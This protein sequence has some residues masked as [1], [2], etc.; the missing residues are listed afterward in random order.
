MQAEQTL[1]SN[2]VYEECDMPLAHT[3]LGNIVKVSDLTRSIQM[4]TANMNQ[5]EYS[6]NE[7][8]IP[9]ESSIA[10]NV[11]ADNQRRATGPFNANSNN[12]SGQLTRGKSTPAIGHNAALDSGKG[13]IVPAGKG[14]QAA[15]VGEYL[16]DSRRSELPTATP[17]SMVASCASQEQFEKS[18]NF[19]ARFLL[20]A[21][22]KQGSDLTAASGN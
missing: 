4:G 16:I 8:S 2:Y 22:W 11:A 13:S 14:K 12:A 19:K 21:V 20:P 1:T 18:P 10:G 17:N 3:G 7:S 15:M 5:A 6:D 9:Q